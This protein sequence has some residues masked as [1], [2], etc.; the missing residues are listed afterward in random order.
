MYDSLPRLGVGLGYGEALHDDILGHASRIDFLEVTADQFLYASP[1]RLGRLLALRGQFPLIPHS[2]GLSVGT[3]APLDTDYLDRLA[4]FVSQAGGSWFSDHLGFTRVPETD[5]QQFVP[6]WF[7][8]ESL[9][10][11]CRNVRQLKS[12]IPTPFLLENIGYDFPV[13]GS[14]M[15][16]AQFITRVLEDSDI[17]LLLDVNIVLMN[18]AMLGY[19][20]YEFLNSIPLERTVQIHVL[21]GQDRAHSGGRRWTQLQGLSRDTP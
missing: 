17:G 5:V 20:P 18:A 9:D 12:R 13:P 2:I 10:A 16:E 8:E 3:A 6:L 19:D 7:T 11:V 14:E 1:D 4:A 15:T 21:G